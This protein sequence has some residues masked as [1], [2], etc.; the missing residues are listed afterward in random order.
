MKKNK[1]FTLVLLASVALF[2]SCGSI[3]GLLTKHKRPVYLMMSPGDLVVKID[4]VKQEIESDIFATYSLNG[5]TINYYTSSI[6]LPYKD[7]VKMEISSQG[8]SAIFE[9]K[10]KNSGAIFWG[11]FIS[12]PI[13]GHIVDGVTK[14]NKTLK[15]RYI[16]VESALA[17]KPSKDWRGKGKLKRL[18]K[19]SIKKG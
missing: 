1:L 5:L 13:V 16:D 10:P 14:N 15:P 18:E 4:G 19:K 17:G 12:F 8:K 7:K 9:L 3:S 2:S 6:R 11:N